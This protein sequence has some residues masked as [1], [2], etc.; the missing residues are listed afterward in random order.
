MY[1]SNPFYDL[2]YAFGYSAV[3]GS[4][5]G[6]ILSIIA[7]IAAIVVSAIL[8][9]KFISEEKVAG[10]ASVKRDW[11][12]FFRFESLLIEKILKALYLFTA[13]FIAFEAV[14]NI[15]TSLTL[16]IYNPGGAILGI[17]SALILGVILEILNRV[18]FEFSLMIVL[19]WKNTSEIKK[20]LTVN[21][22]SENNERASQSGNS[23]AVAASTPVETT[24]AAT[25]VV[26]TP[27]K[28]ATSAVAKPAS[29]VAAA[30]TEPAATPVAPATPA[31]QTAAPVKP[32]AAS[33]T[34]V[35]KEAPA[36]PTAPTDSFKAVKEQ[37]PNA[38]QKT[39]FL[40]PVSESAPSKSE[41]STNSAGQDSWTCSSC[42]TTNKNGNFCAQCGTKREK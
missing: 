24:A 17:I 40:N 14:A 31:E 7:F 28:P 8:Y 3:A 26:A 13:C 12:P 42:G 16:I 27:A 18:G 29:V 21:A 6:I 38:D 36:A 35:Q 1:S 23:D 20:S 39:T 37:A 19:I 30:P 15:I 9:S 34:P 2:G 11:K 25:P 10:S 41:S 22:I 4:G 5:T 33:A 32:T